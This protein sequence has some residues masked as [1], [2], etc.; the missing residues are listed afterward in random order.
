MIRTNTMKLLLNYFYKG[1]LDKMFF[2]FADP[3][4]KRYNHRKRII[5]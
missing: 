4:F 2:C 3:H 1:Q 5:K